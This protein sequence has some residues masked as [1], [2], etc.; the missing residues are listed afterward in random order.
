MDLR[1]GEIILEALMLGDSYA[2][3]WPND[4]PGD[5]LDKRPMIYPCSAFETYVAYSREKPGKRIW[6]AKYWQDEET[7]AYRMTLYYPD[8]IERYSTKE[9]QSTAPAKE[10]AFEP[11]RGPD[12][13]EPETVVN[14][15]GEVPIFHFANNARRLG[16]A[17]QSELKHIIPLQDALNKAVADM[18]VAMEFSAYRQRWVTGLEEVRDPVTQEVINPF[19]PGAD[20]VWSA[21]LE[22]K[23][24]E[25]AQT[26][27]GQFLNVQDSLRSEIARVS[28]TPLHHF[29]LMTG[30][31]PSGESLK[32]AEAPFIAKATDRQISFGNVWEDVIALALRMTGASHAHLTTVWKD[33]APA[34]MTPQAAPTA[35]GAL[36]Q[37]VS[38]PITVNNNGGQTNGR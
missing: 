1:S 31:W 37:E 25:F 28:A 3:V 38:M 8:R 26:D 34:T 7:G 6:A 15:W 33:A 13:N 36:P 4:E 9:K 11:Y 29:M 19:N 23:F 27:L 16:Y 30:S 20:R 32:T 14:E 21:P 12:S 35:P 5:P 2:M 17:G 18:L 10:S 24:G 22:A